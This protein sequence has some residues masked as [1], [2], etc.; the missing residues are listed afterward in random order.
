MVRV[1]PSATAK[2]IELYSII[3]KSDIQPEKLI[4]QVITHISIL[5]S[6]F[7][8]LRSHVSLINDEET[9]SPIQKIFSA[10]CELLKEDYNGQQW[11]NTIEKQF[12]AKIIN[13]LNEADLLGN[14]DVQQYDLDF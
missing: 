3:D 1:H 5:L 2:G 8:S 10:F 7:T 9:L 14:N 11:V 6:P 13:S 12:D 4:T